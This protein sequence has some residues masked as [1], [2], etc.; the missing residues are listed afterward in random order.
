MVCSGVLA[1][2]ED[3]TPERVALVAVVI[4]EIVASAVVSPERYITSPSVKSVIK[5]V[6]TPATAEVD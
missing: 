3:E 6:P 2:K 4:S 5:F 1:S